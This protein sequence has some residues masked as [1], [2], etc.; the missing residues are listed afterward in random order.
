MSADGA[1][2]ARRIDDDVGGLAVGESDSTAQAV[3]IGLRRSFDPD[4]D[5]VRAGGNWMNGEQAVGPDGL[6]ERSVQRDDDCAHLWMDIAED[7]RYTFAREPDLT[8]ATCLVQ[9]K[10]EALSVE[11]R[12]DIVEEGILVWKADHAT[13]GDDQQMRYECAIL[14]NQ[15]EVGWSRLKGW[16]LGDGREPHDDRGRVG[17]GGRAKDDASVER[18]RVGARLLCTSQD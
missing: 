3:E 6:I 2:R 10:I 18:G 4:M 7:V 1:V 15:R 16:R 11:K 9:A 5:L 14:L 8:R 13:H 12:K 17:L